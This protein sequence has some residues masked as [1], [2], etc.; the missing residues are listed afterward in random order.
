MKRKIPNHKRKKENLNIP[1]TTKQKEEIEKKATE[2]E[3]TVAEFARNILFP[4]NK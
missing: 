2:Q 1:I 3:I 4:K